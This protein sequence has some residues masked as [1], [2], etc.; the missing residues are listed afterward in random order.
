MV[1]SRDERRKIYETERIRLK[2]R[3]DFERHGPLGCGCFI[4]LIVL[5]AVGVVIFISRS[6]KPP[7]WWP[8]WLRRPPTTQPADDTPPADTPEE[9][10][11]PAESPDLPA[12]PQPDPDGTPDDPEA[13][14]ASP[15][16]LREPEPGPSEPS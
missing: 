13:D 5:L 3:D 11:P 6:E 9:V 16:W 4:V 8:Q 15:S 2:A 7:A 1:M 14:D 10:I 12:E